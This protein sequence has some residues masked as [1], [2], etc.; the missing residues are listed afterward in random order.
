[1][2]RSRV[3]SQLQRSPNA[4]VIDENY[5]ETVNDTEICPRN[6]QNQRCKCAEPRPFELREPGEN[7][8]DPGWCFLEHVSNPENPS[9]NCFE[10]A[11]W[12]PTHGRFFS[13]LACQTEEGEGIIGRASIPDPPAYYDE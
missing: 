10:D 7:C 11:Y 2:V 9:E 13:S 5:L 12:S 1:M 8:Q 6:Q 3:Q 4:F